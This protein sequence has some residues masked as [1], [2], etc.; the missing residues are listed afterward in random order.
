M[1]F[2]PLLPTMA[3]LDRDD[4]AKAADLREEILEMVREHMDGNVVRYMYLMS[5]AVKV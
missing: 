5:A 3:R 2:S 1:S 4:P